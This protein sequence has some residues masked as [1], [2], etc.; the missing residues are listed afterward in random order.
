M[1]ADYGQPFQINRKEVKL[2]EKQPAFSSQAEY[3]KLLFH[4]VKVYAYH[5][6]KQQE[7]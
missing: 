6:D 4:I 7:Q 1:L 2:Y 5:P 3:W